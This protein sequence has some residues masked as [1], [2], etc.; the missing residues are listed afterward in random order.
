MASSGSEIERSYRVDV[1]TIF[2]EFV[3]S[4]AQHGVV[5][6]AYDR[7]ILDLNTIN[8]RDFAHDK[9]RTVDDRVYG[10]GPGMVMKYQPLFDS[11]Q[12]AKT[13]CK[14]SYKNSGK[15]NYQANEI[16]DN[17]RKV[18]YLSPQGRP[19]DQK[20]VNELAIE[21]GL[22]L[23][24][25]RYEGVDERLIEATVDYEVSL[26]DFV[27][28]GGEIASMALI[29]AVVRQLPGV[30]G[31]SESA[32]QDSFMDGLL[33]CPHYTRPEEI[34]ERS[35]PAV[36]LGGDHAKIQRWRKK[37]SLGRTYLRR[38]ELMSGLE[39][40]KESKLLLEEFIHEESLSNDD[41]V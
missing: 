7:G 30:L 31:D 8:P 10:G 19:L 3:M 24:S 16:G 1:I 33:D 25:G 17:P 38:P 12:F 13:S 32:E 36:L 37:Q 40:D 6:R 20:L 26:G 5:G 21:D 39:L 22:I 4:V 29:D 23:L 2:P 41:L 11:V 35:V 27:L 18:V 34:D 14:N 28:S 9:H 15:E